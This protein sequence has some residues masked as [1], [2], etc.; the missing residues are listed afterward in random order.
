[1]EEFE[2]SKKFLEEKED[3]GENINIADYE[4]MKH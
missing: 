2:K 4:E 3:A 1:M